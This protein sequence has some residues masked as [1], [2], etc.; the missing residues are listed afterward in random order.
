LG[1]LD[2]EYL[3]TL[4]I[5]MYV[6]AHRKHNNPEKIRFLCRMR[7]IFWLNVKFSFT[8]PTTFHMRKNLGAKKCVKNS[9]VLN[10]VVPSELVSLQLFF[11]VSAISTIHTEILGIINPYPA[12]VENTVNS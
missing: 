10:T 2:E 4:K 1:S 8:L 9:F 6:A 12:N 11:Y 7:D 5:F 3:L